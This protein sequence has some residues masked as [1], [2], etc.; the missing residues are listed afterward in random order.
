MQWW[1]PTGEQAILH[2]LRWCALIQKLCTGLRANKVAEDK[3]K[4][5]NA[6]GVGVFNAIPSFGKFKRQRRL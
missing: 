3:T 2:H 4:N 5:F 1:L 6:Q